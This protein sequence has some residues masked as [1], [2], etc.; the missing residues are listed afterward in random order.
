MFFFF[1]FS[2][3]IISE[4]FLIIRIIERDMII[5]VYWSTCKVSVIHVTFLI[6]L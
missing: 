5:N 6:K 1:V 2:P 4:T 3:Q